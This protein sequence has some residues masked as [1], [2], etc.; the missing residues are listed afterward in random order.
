MCTATWWSITN[1]NRKTFLKDYVL[2]VPTQT[3][4]DKYIL[5]T[6]TGTP[7][8]LV[9]RSCPKTLNLDQDVGLL[10]FL[11]VD[12]EIAMTSG[13][14]VRILADQYSATSFE[15]DMHKSQ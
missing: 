2:K 11:S 1:C 9:A 5:F 13:L 12:S 14:V 10:H 3:V 15:I 4:L 8:A 7:P 6:K